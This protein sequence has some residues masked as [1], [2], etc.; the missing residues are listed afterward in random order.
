MAWFAQGK[1]RESHDYACQAIT[2]DSTDA[3]AHFLKGMTQYYLLKVS[4]TDETK[5]QV[6]KELDIAL[7]LDPNNNY[8]YS[9]RAYIRNEFGDHEGA[10]NDAKKVEMLGGNDAEMLMNAYCTNHKKEKQ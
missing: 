3:Q 4:S 1:Y 8:F 6:T 9:Q 7:N 2:F 10:C 5:Q